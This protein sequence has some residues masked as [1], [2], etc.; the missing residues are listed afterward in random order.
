M[1]SFDYILQPGSGVNRIINSNTQIQT[2]KHTLQTHTHSQREREF[3]DLHRECMK[4]YWHQ[5][6]VHWN[7]STP[8]ER[9][10]ERRTPSC[11]TREC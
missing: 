11:L 1:F 6:D 10:P 2:K 4:V 3:P 8:R 9:E 7:G 5:T